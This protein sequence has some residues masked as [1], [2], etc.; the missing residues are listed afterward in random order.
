MG[1]FDSVDIKEVS[2]DII[3]I[4]ID[5]NGN[6]IGKDISIV[7][8]QAHDFGLNLLSSNYFND[9]RST[10]QDLKDWKNGFSF[11]LEAIKQKMEYRR[12]IIDKIKDKLENEHRLIIVG[13]S[14]TSKSTVLMEIICEYFDNGYKVLY[15]FGE[16]EIMNVTELVQ[17]VEGLLKGN[18]KVL[19]AVD[20]VHNER[21]AAIFYIID[22]LS[23][24]HLS[25]NLLFVLTARLPEFDWFTNDRLNTVDESYRESIRKFVQVSKYR[26]ELEPF[27]MNEIEE[28]IKMYQ[29]LGTTVSNIKS[30][31]LAAQIFDTTKGLP[32]MVKFYI[33]GKGL[34]EDVEDRYYRYLTDPPT[35]TEQ[36]SSL[37]RIQVMLI[38][39][40]L[41]IANLPI[42]NKLLE[43]MGILSTAYD[44]EN[45]MLYQYSDELWK[46][47]HPRWDMELLSFLYSG[48]NKSILLKRKEDLKKALVSIFNI[49]DESITASTI[50]T[51][52]DIASSKKIPINVVESSTD[53]PNY[54]NS[55]T[56]FN[57]Y[58]LAIALTYRNLQMYTEMLSNCNRALELKPG[59]VTALNAK[60]LSLGLLKNYEESLKCCD[61]IIETDRND[62][63]AWTNKGLA[64]NGLRKYNE[65]LECWKT[66]VEIDDNY[67][68]TWNRTSN[69]SKEIKGYD[70]SVLRRV[71]VIKFAGKAISYA[72]MKKYEQALE[73]SSRALEI[74]ENN[75]DNLNSRAWALN[76]L[77]RY[78]EALECSNK[79]LEYDS[80]R[81]W[82]LTNQ[83]WALNG[84]KRYEEALECSNKALELNV[85]TTNF[86]AWNNKAA[87]LNGLKRY[88]EALECSNKALKLSPFNDWGWFIKGLILNGLKRYE[89]ALECSNKALELDVNNDWT[90]NNKAWALINLSKNEEALECSN[91]ALELDPRCAWAW[92]NKLI[93]LNRLGKYNEAT[94]CSN[95]ASKLDP[96]TIPNW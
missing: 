1:K 29:D 31:N 11:K 60:A 13:D 75:S 8:N 66:A 3:G 71:L 28:F 2:G 22:Q 87:A 81:A 41:D 4:G 62:V 33:F 51:V 36:Q 18:N 6:I 70:D 96:V 53:I 40:L 65:A 89:E 9:Y 24:Y 43:K 17:F 38:C 63:G 76:G 68:D 25:K 77:K 20:N 7:I 45:A 46:T 35:V 37:T 84:L 47:L 50:Q 16:T 88:E 49:S 34:E 93:A 95:K 39:A 83:A 26:Y 15:N 19:I 58:L 30:D 80:N 32:I 69:S 94:E 73:C 72:F 67:V 10:E 79:A 85:D 27:T 12:N 78:E 82:T 23:N 52:Y 74:D 92:N 56:K 21:T 57:L 54:L 64:L 61:E 55:E 5:G 44:L 90:W 59:D 91:K 86:S 14:G 42:T 48:K